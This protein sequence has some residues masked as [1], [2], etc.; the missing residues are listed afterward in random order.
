MPWSW[1]WLTPLQKRSR[2]S[3]NGDENE[4]AA[5]GKQP[6]QFSFAVRAIEL[7]IG[8]IHRGWGDFRVRVPVV[9]RPTIP[10][11]RFNLPEDPEEGLFQQRV[12]ISI[13]D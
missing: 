11:L 8:R 7:P 1:A 12:P 3:Q 10:P 13:H 4:E 9:R 5:R 2:A 6:R